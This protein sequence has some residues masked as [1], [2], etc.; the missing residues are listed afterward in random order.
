MTNLYNIK[1]CY[2]YKYKLSIL[3]KFYII[4]PKKYNTIYIYLF[5][6][7]YTVYKYKGKTQ[8][9]KKEDTLVDLS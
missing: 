1:I 6:F 7:Q 4:H 2:I 5:K 3:L 8:I 9:R